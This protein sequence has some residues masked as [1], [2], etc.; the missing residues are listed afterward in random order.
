VDERVR[1]LVVD[2][3]ISIGDYVLSGGE[4]AAMVLIE[5][6]SRQIPGVVGRPDSV[7]KD[8]FRGGLLDFPHYT[9]PRVVEDL[10]VPE[11]LLSG[12]HK[13]IETWRQQQAL[14]ATLR[15]RPDL[16]ETANLT[17]A[18]LKMLEELKAKEPATDD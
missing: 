11:I 10:E 7:E 8:S 16:L 1:N 5:V 14:S 12:D 17:E 9:R 15:K 2:E 4:V 13:A 18:Q 3:E 6:I